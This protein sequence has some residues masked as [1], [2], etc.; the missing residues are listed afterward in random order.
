MRY[1]AA[2]ERRNTTAPAISGA[3]PTRPSGDFWASL[4]TKSGSSR[5]IF[6]FGNGP[7]EMERAA[8]KLHES[9][10]ANAC[11]VD[12]RDSPL[13]TDHTVDV[14]TTFDCIHDM[15]RPQ[16]MIHAIR[17]ALAPNGTWLLVDIK[18]QDSFADNARK[19]PMAA[20]MYGISVLSCMSSAMSSADG[21]GLGTLGFSENKARQMANVA[22]FTRFR[23]LDVDHSV[24]AFYEVRP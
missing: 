18:A 24:N 3:W 7:G 12:P 16:D 23:R 4:A 20:L 2:S 9:A 19:N 6:G 13:P 5:W 17:A 14:V 1:D 10:V 21:E 22:G 8:E 11:F 15:T